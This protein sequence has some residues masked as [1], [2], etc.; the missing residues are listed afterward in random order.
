MKINLLKLLNEKN[1]NQSELAKLTGIRPSTICGMCNNN[2]I[3]LKAE[4]I[5]KICSV[6][7]CRLDELITVKDG[8]KY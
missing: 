3:Y 1:M 2:S 6:L 7:N 5:D 4:N 8:V